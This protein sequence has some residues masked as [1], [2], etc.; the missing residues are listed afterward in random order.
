[1]F[2]L[3]PDPTFWSKVQIPV[4]G[5]EP[6]PLEVEFR[7]RTVDDLQAFAAAMRDRAPL[8]VCADML[9]SW[10]EADEEFSRDSLARLLQNYPLA[11]DTFATSYLAAFRDAKRGN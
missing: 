10:R 9:V 6:Q 3:Q 1:M 5:G 4:T 8:D 7:H 11:A 2:K